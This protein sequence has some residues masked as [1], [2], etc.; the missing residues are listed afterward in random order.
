MEIIKPSVEILR[1]TDDPLQLIEIAGR[2]CYKSED[3]ITDTSYKDFVKKILNLRH[4]SVLEHVVVTFRF[5]CDR[6]VTHE[7]VRHRIAS[8]SQES[9][10]YCTY[11]PDK[12]GMKFILP[13]DF[14]LDETDLNLLRAIED[15]YNACLYKGRTPQQARFFLPNG[16]KTEIISTM[17]IRELRHFFKLRRSKAAHPSMREVANMLYDKLNENLSILFQEEI[18]V[19]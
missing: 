5:I 16:L 19:T 3:K 4:E 8:Y 13:C 2:L 15:H 9:T 18:N 10:R 6:G 17:N 14:E 7:L 11:S 1:I 12:M